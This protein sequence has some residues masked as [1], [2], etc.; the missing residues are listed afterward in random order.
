MVAMAQERE[1]VSGKG[2]ERARA[3]GGGEGGRGTRMVVLAALAAPAVPVD[4]EWV[5]LVAVRGW[6]AV[7]GR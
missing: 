2:G 4:R 3:G 1:V 7:V 5:D 6:E